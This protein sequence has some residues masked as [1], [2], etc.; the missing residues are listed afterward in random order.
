MD[1][2]IL[3]WNIFGLRNKIAQLQTYLGEHK[4][5]AICLQETLCYDNKYPSLPNYTIVKHDSNLGVHR[6]ML[7]AVRSDVPYTTNDFIDIGISAHHLLDITFTL[8][9]K[10]IRL[11]NIYRGHAENNTLNFHN[12]VNT[13]KGQMIVCGD[14][15]A[16]HTSWGRINNDHGPILSSHLNDIGVFT[17]LNNGDPTYVSGSSIDLTLVTNELVPLCS[18]KV[19]DELFSDHHAIEIGIELNHSIAPCPGG[20][21]ITKNANWHV[22]NH[23]LEETVNETPVGACAEEEAAILTSILENTLHKSFKKTK[24]AAK[25]RARPLWQFDD[26]YIRHRNIVNRLTR[27]FRQTRD[28]EILKELRTAQKLAN[29]VA[30]VAKRNTWLEWCA[31]LDHNTTVADMWK[32]LRAIEGKN[33]PQKLHPNPEAESNRLIHSYVNRSSSLQLPH[34][35]KRTQD[36]VKATRMH[37]LHNHTLMTDITDQPFMYHELRN[38]LIKRKNTAPGE[39]G[40]T[41]CILQKSCP[42][43]LN[44][45]LNLCNMSWEEGKLPGFWKNAIIHGIPKPSDPENPRPIS[46]LSVL[47]KILEKMVHSRLLWKVSPLSGNI[48]AYLPGRSTQD[49]ITSLLALV[50][51]TRGTNIK[52]KPIA[53]FLDLEKAFELSSKLA[54]TELLI[55][56]GVKGKML[57]WIADYLTDRTAQVRFQGVL[58]DKLPF[59]LGTPQGSILSPLLFNLLMEDMVCQTY[60]QYTT[61]MSYADDIVIVNTNPSEESLTEDLSQIEKCCDRLGLKISAKKSK[62]LHFKSINKHYE[63]PFSLNIQNENLEWVKEYKYLGIILDNRLCLSKH[64]DAIKDRITARLNV[65]RAISGHK[66]GASYHV[67]KTFYCAAVRSVIEYGNT[68]LSLASKTQLEELDKLQNKALRL[69]TRA[70]IWTNISTLEHVTN[71]DPLHIRRTESNLKVLDKTMRDQSHPNH[72]PLVS[73]FQNR[74]AGYVAKS[75]NSIAREIWNSSKL[76]MP[77]IECS[78]PLPPWASEIATFIIN[79]PEHKK[80][81]CIPAELRSTALEQIYQFWNKHTILIYTDGALDPDTGRAGCGV[82]IRYKNQT[83]K[84]SLRVENGASSL[85]TELL[86]IQE[87]LHHITL[88]PENAQIVLCTDS[89]GSL[90]VLQQKA[91]TDNIDIVESIKTSLQNRAAAKNIFI[92]V[93]SHVG[94][95]GNETA[96]KLAKESLLRE[97]ID[98]DISIL[99][100]SKQRSLTS[101]YTNF[102]LSEHHQKRTAESETF[103]NY[104]K[105]TKLKKVCMPRSLPRSQEREVLFLILGYKLY[106]EGPFRSSQK[107][108]CPDCD[109]FEYNIMH[110]LFSCQLHETE[111]KI[112]TETI[113]NNID[114]NEKLVHVTQMALSNPFPLINFFQKHRPPWFVRATP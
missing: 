2:K 3:Q 84:L 60:T 95:P 43:F 101:K 89:L 15:N 42:S 32:K 12:I 76:S 109:A 27:M 10:N 50:T 70:P 67:L 78:N 26:D 52:N 54:I 21:W 80:S 82:Y 93:P 18:W 56:K 62:I 25:A 91:C 72:K 108:K 23:H 79:T 113:P 33:R 87:A 65:M 22:F 106:L 4:P 64:V 105:R 34:A 40:F 37:E 45:L 69:I 102:M 71:I 66:G 88:F 51:S 73:L 46:L 92:W 63:P 36:M 17:V 35:V 83:I 103:G 1:N 97:T 90:Q 44:R 31:E 68:A 6:G 75:W 100:R 38:A 61:V 58:S 86:A 81:E 47:D 85:Q 99:S 16:S 55:K 20:K 112:L 39:D 28:P 14:F 111:S 96:D 77:T 30:C 114:L 104:A 29:K 57:A 107:G 74:S 49:C 13:Y 53:I 9:S 41:F 24:P 98:I 48:R 110:H 19:C 8:G 5:V 11:L 7:T 59:E 94:I